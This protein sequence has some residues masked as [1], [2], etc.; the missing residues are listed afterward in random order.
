[1]I[2]YMRHYT[3][4]L[5]LVLYT[6]ETLSKPLDTSKNV[7]TMSKPN[8]TGKNKGDSKDKIEYNLPASPV[9]IKI[10]GK[11]VNIEPKK[12][13]CLLEDVGPETD[14]PMKVSE[15]LSDF[16][17]KTPAECRNGCN[18]SVECNFGRYYDSIER[19]FLYYVGDTNWECK[20]IHFEFMKN[21]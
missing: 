15:I 1:M 2:A 6:L 20:V 10:D 17:A 21:Y 9:K 11:T 8:N 3:I 12:Q 4:V 5:L 18:K 14:L 19:C 16:D 7:K 13:P